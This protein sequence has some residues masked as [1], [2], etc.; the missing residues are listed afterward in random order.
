MSAIVRLLL[1]TLAFWL[2]AEMGNVRKQVDYDF[3][4]EK[5]HVTVQLEM[6]CCFIHLKCLPDELDVDEQTHQCT[7][8]DLDSVY[9]FG[10]NGRAVLLQAN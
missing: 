3:P 6:F 7:E 10:P 5:V 9:S 2:Q 1:A 4:N 8:S